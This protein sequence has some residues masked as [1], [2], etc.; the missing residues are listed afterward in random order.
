MAVLAWGSSAL[1]FVLL[2]GMSVFAVADHRYGDLGGVLQIL[3][4]A[5][6]GLL[7][8]RAR[9][10]NAV[11]WL[12]LGLGFLIAELVFA[13]DYAIYALRVNPG[14]LPG[15]NI[16]AWFGVWPIELITG[17]VALALIL[18]PHGTPPTRRWRLLVAAIVIGTAGQTILSAGWNVNLTVPFN[19]PEATHPLSLPGL[20]FVRPVY[21]ALQTLTILWLL[22]TVVAIAVRY[23]RGDYT[24]RTQLKWV[25][26]AVAL[27]GVGMA[28][29]VL[30]L[31]YRAVI[32]W[33][34]ISPLVP[35]SAG[36]AIRRYRLYEIDRI[37]NRTAVYALVTGILVG[38][39]LGL[40]LLIQTVSPLGNHSSAAV[41]LS[42][43]ATAALFRPVRAR[44]QTLVDRRF[45]RSRYDAAQTLTAF[46]ARVRNEVDIYAWSDELLSVVN[47]TM[48]PRTVSIWL[49]PNPQNA[50][51]AP[52]GN[53]MSP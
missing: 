12:F 1:T 17:V 8:T 24:E 40:I 20:S 47:A 33:T 46:A 7:I 2:C 22:S 51:P 4:F 36:V 35:I 50:P 11:G 49:R 31:D 26:S 13:R 32:V 3:A 9:P 41:A 10:R 52:R 48:S 45:N 18:F 28:L 38:A 53:P 14:S 42:T 19:F 23:R 5:A 37:I 15:G 30:I 43:L 27:L 39:Y 6:V 29:A 34:L 21:G 44:V 16:A 25:M